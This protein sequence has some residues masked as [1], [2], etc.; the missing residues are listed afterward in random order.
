M[1]RRQ[2]I[3]HKFKINTIK[4]VHCVYEALELSV[5]EN[6]RFTDAKTHKWKF[7][8]R[9][10]NQIEHNL[11]SCDRHLLLSQVFLQ[12]L[13]SCSSNV[14]SNAMKYVVYVRM[15]WLFFSLLLSNYEC[16][17]NWWSVLRPT[18]HNECDVEPNRTLHP[19]LGCM[20]LMI[21]HAIGKHL[22]NNNK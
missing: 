7:E 2:W 17:L 1:V 14:Y 15:L 13:F 6:V 20:W 18:I 5:S 19:C 8:R 4:R 12:Y 9:F 11:K 21:N 16:Q 10:T 22:Y 3:S